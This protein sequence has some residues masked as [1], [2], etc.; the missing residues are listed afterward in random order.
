[1]RLF[2]KKPPPT[3]K[4]LLDKSLPDKL[5][6]REELTPD[7]LRLLIKDHWLLGD[8]YE[9]AF[10]LLRRIEALEGTQAKLSDRVFGE[11]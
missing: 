5:Y 6:D 8:E 3:E 11:L 7:E 4:Q 10:Q 9:L 1:M 2:K